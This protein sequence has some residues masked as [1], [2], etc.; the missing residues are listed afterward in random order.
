MAPGVQ[1]RAAH[2][3]M[4][5]NPKRLTGVMEK[6]F[7]GLRSESDD[8]DIG[9]RVAATLSGLRNSNCAESVGF[10]VLRQTGKVSTD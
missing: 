3:L 1:D 5:T 10:C 6:S 8:F 7:P 4:A 9:K 2:K